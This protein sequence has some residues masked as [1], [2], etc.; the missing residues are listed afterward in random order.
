MTFTKDHLKNRMKILKEHFNDSYDFFRGGKLSGFSW[1]LFTKTW[2]DKPKVW[3]QLISENSE[4]I[5]W[6]NKVVNNYDS[7]EELFAKDRAMG[8]GVETAKEKHRHWI[9]EPNGMNLESIVDID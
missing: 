7:L 8:Q 5:K 6:R 2:C 3:E 9:S 4:A 1:N